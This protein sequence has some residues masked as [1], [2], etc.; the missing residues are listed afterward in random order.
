MKL[1]EQLNPYRQR[2]GRKD[3]TER[4]ICDT[5]SPVP[6]LKLL[7]GHSTPH[8]Q[9]TSVLPEQWGSTVVVLWCLQITD[10]SY[11]EAWLGVSQQILV[12]P[13]PLTT[14]GDSRDVTAVQ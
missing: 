14:R 10:D 5:L 1:T 4:R 13:T 6:A 3:D 2:E 12:Y 11:N 7:L 9:L 8:P